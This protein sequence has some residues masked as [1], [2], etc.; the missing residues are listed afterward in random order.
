MAELIAVTGFECVDVM[1]RVRV[2][3]GKKSGLLYTKAEEYCTPRHSLNKSPSSNYC[4]EKAKKALNC[5]KDARS[6]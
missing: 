1:R 3:Y 5:F 6:T 4:L 2:I